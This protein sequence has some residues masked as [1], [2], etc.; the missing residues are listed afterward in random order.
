[1]ILTNSK[2]G[3]VGRT[4]RAPPLR[5]LVLGY[6]TSTRLTGIESSGLPLPVKRRPGTPGTLDYQAFR[7]PG[8]SGAYK[9]VRARHEV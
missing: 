4:V 6:A 9:G 8:F 7:A 3:C 5:A 1:V 2:P